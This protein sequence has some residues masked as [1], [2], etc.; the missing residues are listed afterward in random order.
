MSCRLRIVCGLVVLLATA[1]PP[2]ANAEAPPSRL[3]LHPARIDLHGPGARHRLL[4]TAHF[5]DGHRHDVTAVASFA[6]AN[7]AVATVSA[8]GECAAVADG[9]TTLTVTYAGRTAELPVA[10]AGTREVAPPSFVNGVLP[11]LTRFGCNAGACHGKAAGQNGFRLSLRGYA[12]ELDY[13]WLTR[14]FA[15]RRVAASTPDESLL[16]QK[17]LGQAPHAGGRLFTPGSRAHRI[18]RDWLAAGMPA[19][20]PNEPTAR[21]IEILPGPRTLA[22][23]EEQQMLV[24]AEYAP[25]VWRDVTWLAR[26]D[27]NDPGQVEITPGGRV[28]A[29]RPGE[30]A[31]RAAFQS[32]VAAAVI[33]V[34]FAQSIPA[35]RY[36]A[37]NNLIDAHVFRK[38]AVLHIEP[39]ELCG[40]AEFVRRVFL[41][42]IGTLPTPEEVRAFLTDP[43][44]D[45]RSRLIDELL[46]RPEWV[47]YWTLFLADLLQNRRERD[48]DARG[49]K[50]VRSLHAWL[51][52][53]LARNRP[54]DELARDV[55]TATGSSSDAPAVGYYVVTIGEQ[56]EVE[57]S[58]V[59]DSVAQAFLGTRI[60]CARCHNHPLERY[61]QDDFY[62]FAAF[63]SRTL[64]ER[65]AGM[66]PGPVVLRV[67][68]PNPRQNNLPP[69]VIQPRTNQY[70]PPQPLD[71]S[72]VA[73]RP[74][75]DPR[76]KLAAWVTDPRNEFFSGAMVNRLWRHFLGVGLVEPVDDLR[77]TNPPTNPELWQVLKREFVAHKFD[78]KHLQRL[79]LSSRTYQLTSATK[80]TNA[81]DTHFYSHYYARRLPAEVLLDALDQAAGVP[82][83]FPGYPT[84]LRAVQLPDP[85][86]KSYFLGLFGRPERATACACERS[87]EVTVPQLLYLQN[88]DS[89]MQKLRAADGR[90]GQLLASQRP[91]DAITDELFLAAL[92]RPPRAAERAAVRQAL[93]DA[94]DRAE[95]FR[96]LLWAL[97]NS[98]EFA[99]NH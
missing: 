95:A 85:G 79:I 17:P 68:A 75:G 12:P 91:D 55:L 94:G 61:T 69:G 72:P 86:L 25:G 99:F 38:L 14:E 33:T 30:T 42:T 60:G 74:G 2:R 39:S 81:A 93:A 43:R 82:E 26:F 37:R 46:E 11:V 47:D 97:L 70:L 80:P 4:V 65:P 15:A 8:I 18:L 45:K 9:T 3:E 62:H 29:L 63:F 1:F 21:R 78:L 98:K 89:L 90:L 48:R 71:R 77:A 5:A 87:V 34:P 23:G 35:E 19:P 84:G 13:R 24:R 96:D 54:W 59:T 51:R 88:G 44:P 27:S 31:I 76:A 7:L 52:G 32:E 83:A 20:P 73:V 28:K 16:L 64:I 6:S 41:D 66:A 57:K 53:Q 49:T 40:D 36:A 50:G 92:S 56:R 22:V 10:V 58:E 67:A